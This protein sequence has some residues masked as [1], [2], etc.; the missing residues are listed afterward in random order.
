MILWRRML[1][2]GF[3]VNHVYEFALNAGSDWVWLSPGSAL[4]T[5]LW[6]LVSFGFQST[7]ARSAPARRYTAPSPGHRDD[8]LALSVRVRAA[9]PS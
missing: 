1:L 6:L 4:A 2:V 3:A 9:R 8:A 5:G 7:C